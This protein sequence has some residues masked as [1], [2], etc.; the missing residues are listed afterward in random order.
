MISFN[1]NTII[2]PI[3]M[4]T[5]SMMV[6][7]VIAGMLTALKPELRIS[8]SS[9]NEWSKQLDTTAYIHLLGFEN[10]Y[11][12]Q[13]F[14]ETEQTPISL[15]TL[16]FELAT[17]INP[18]DPRSLLG[19][20]LPGFSLFDG[21]IIVAGQGTNY[22][23][24][25]IESSPPMEVLLQER[26]ASIESLEKLDESKNVN[27]P[28]MTTNGKKVVYIYTTHSRE[29]YLPHLPEGTK[30]S[31]AYSHEANVMTVAEKLS[32]ELENRGI[33]TQFEGT[34]ITKLLSD[35]GLNYSKSYEVS[36]PVVKDAMANNRDLRY[37][38]DIHRDSQPHKIT[39]TK[40][41]GK[42]Y[43]RTIF[44]IGGEHAKYE[45]NLKM[46]TDLHNLLEKEYPSLSRGVT[47]K[48][49]EG[50]NGKFN[51]DL[52]E[53]AILIEM[54]G[55]ENSLEEVYRTVEAIAEI[56]SE[57]YWQAEEVNG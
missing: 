31:E 26:E 17:S 20:E 13:A 19:R 37:F 56:F 50:T 55:P 4:V 53:N 47:K 11:F 51:Q 2:K 39:T 5:I 34:D 41:N 22:T 40:I 3:I 24:M 36:R 43:A 25:P 6:M 15:S 52:S 45:Q 8:S 27:P 28:T 35:K 38:I 23:N 49:G 7:F 18:N 42:D 48:Q 32:K 21:E 30:V 54:G 57:Y 1:G 9:I 12:K 46:A 33:G 14:E 29:S 10:Q 16:F 44:I